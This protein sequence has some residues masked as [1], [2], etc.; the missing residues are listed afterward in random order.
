MRKR[1]SL[2]G[3]GNIGGTLALLAAIKDLGDIVLIDVVEGTPQGKAL[4]IS[5]AGSIE[6]FEAVIT[7]SNNLEDIK[8]SE[9]IIVTAGVSRKPGMSRDDLL[10][11][12]ADIVSK[13][14]KE[15][16]KHAP[17]A[18]V[19]MVTNPLDAMVWLMQQESGLPHSHVVGMAGI[20]DSA[21]FNHFLSL[22]FNLHPKDIHAMVLGGHGDEMVPLLTHSTVK[23]IPL[24]T[25]VT[26]GQITEDRLNEIIERTRN[27]GAEIVSLLKTGSAFYAP[28]SAAIQMAE[29]YLGDQKRILPCAAYLMGEYGIKGFYVGVPTQIGSQGVERIIEL[30]IS[31]QEQAMLDH[32]ASSVQGL[33]DQLKS[34]GY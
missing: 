20:L 30:P 33:I 22:E 4:D 18:F 26:S 10:K 31:P 16:K 1:I 34:L 7:G 24:T 23:G 28:A 15:I 19:I 13:I 12:N 8:G 29:S 9:V 6:S 11:I 32:S 27:G 3:A 2:I 5:Q 21:R 17:N 25:L 14:S